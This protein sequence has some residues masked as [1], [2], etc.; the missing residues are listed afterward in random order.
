MDGYEELVAHSAGSLPPYVDI[1][2]WS[3]NCFE[4]AE[5]T[6]STGNLYALLDTINGEW[7]IKT[8]LQDSEPDIYK[9]EAGRLIE[10]KQE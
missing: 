8:G 10:Y 4:R 1:Y 2:R 6:E 9:Y 7:I 5:I 3:N